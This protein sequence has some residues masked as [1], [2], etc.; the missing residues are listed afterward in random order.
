MKTTRILKLIGIILIG[1]FLTTQVEANDRS[2]KV[3]E[4]KA[5]ELTIDK[6]ILDFIANIYGNQINAKDIIRMQKMLRQIDHITISFRDGDAS[7]YQL[8]FQ[9]M[10]DQDLEIWMFD[11]G[12]LASDNET[13]M[14]V[15][16][17]WMENI[18]FTSGDETEI[19][20]SVPWM[21]YMHLG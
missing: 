5:I 4:K 8:K 3:A 20:V 21:E 10:D 1:L 18:R 19:E 16:V 9:P 7:D 13:E 12:Y 2:N 15:S 6:P 11:Q 17:P 14:E